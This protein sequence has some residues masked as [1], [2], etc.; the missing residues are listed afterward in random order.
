MVKT[1]QK[2]KPTAANTSS[3]TPMQVHRDGKECHRSF[4]DCRNNVTLGEIECPAAHEASFSVIRILLVFGS[5]LK[6]IL[7]LSPR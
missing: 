4:L 3:T 1:L 7:V 6:K 2:T 5:S